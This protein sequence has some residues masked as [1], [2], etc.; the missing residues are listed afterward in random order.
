MKDLQRKYFWKEEEGRKSED[1][2]GRRGWRQKT[3]RPEL[4]GKKSE[5]CSMYK[6]M[7]KRIPIP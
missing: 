3:G 6:F 2:Q 4:G 1:N 7:S 5:Q